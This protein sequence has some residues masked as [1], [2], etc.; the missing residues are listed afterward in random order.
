MTIDLSVQI[1]FPLF[2]GRYGV[3]FKLFLCEIWTMIS[4]LHVKS[5]YVLQEAQ[6]I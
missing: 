6:K 5:L 1:R 2:P 3:C 4:K